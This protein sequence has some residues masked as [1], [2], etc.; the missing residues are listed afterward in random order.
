[1]ELGELAVRMTDMVEQNVVNPQLRTWIMPSFSTTAD[2]DKVVAATLMMGSLQKYFS[3]RMSLCYG[4][5]SVTLL[6][7]R[8]DWEQLVIKLDNIPTLGKGPH[9]FCSSSPPGIRT[10]RSHLRSPK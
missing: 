2:S 8:E 5:S 1:M 9:N 7:N 3:Y 4:I 10:L 6:R